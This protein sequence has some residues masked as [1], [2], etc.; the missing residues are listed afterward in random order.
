MGEEVALF[1]LRPRLFLGK[2]YLERFFLLLDRIFNSF[3]ERSREYG[4]WN[5]VLEV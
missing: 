5:D 2:L 4:P 1:L 3:V